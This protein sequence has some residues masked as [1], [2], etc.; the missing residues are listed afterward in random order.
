MLGQL[1]CYDQQWHWR[2]ATG[3]GISCWLAAGAKT[4]QFGKIEKALVMESAGHAAHDR[5]YTQTVAGYSSPADF[6]VVAHRVQ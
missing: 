4:K 6:V 5:T 1:R 3:A 2:W